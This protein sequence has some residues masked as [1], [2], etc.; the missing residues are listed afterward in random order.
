MASRSFS[1]ETDTPSSDG[2]TS[3]RA[4]TCCCASQ[5]YSIDGKSRAV[6]TNLFRAGDLKL[7]HD[8]T[9]ASAIDACGWIGTDPAEPPSMRAMR[10]PM[11]CDSS[12]QFVAHASSLVWC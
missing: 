5:I 11:R 3:M 9:V 6:V 7:K 10:S 12:H 8:A 1:K 2:T 4:P